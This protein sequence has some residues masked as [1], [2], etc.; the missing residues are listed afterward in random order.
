LSQLEGD[1]NIGIGDPKYN[2]VS[3]DYEPNPLNIAAQY[4]PAA[5]NIGMGFLPSEDYTGALGRM[6]PVDMPEI[7]PGQELV[8][9][10]QGFASAQD[11]LGAVTGTTPGAYLSGLQSLQDSRNETTAKL[12]TQLRNNGTST[13]RSSRSS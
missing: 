2:N 5:A 4:I 6:Q 13:Y 1:E 9:I 11:A 7:V 12:F 8:N 10:N 3:F